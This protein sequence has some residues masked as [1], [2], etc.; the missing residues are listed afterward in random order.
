MR[1]AGSAAGDAVSGAWPLGRGFGLLS[2][3]TLATTYALVVL[4]GVVR[5]TAS[6]DACPDWPRCHGQLIPPFETAVLIEFSHRLLASVVGFLVLAVAIVVWRH[7]KDRPLIAWAGLTA[8]AM[9]IGQIILGGLT[10][11]N[12]LSA[13][14]VMAHL[15]MASVLLA[16]LIVIT[17][18]AVVPPLQSTDEGGV[19]SYAFRNQLIV[20]AIAIFALML[21]GSYVSGSGAALAY[22]DWPL[23]DGALLP[24]GG[25]L[26][27]IH[28][29]HRFSVLFVG[30][31]VAYVAA[32][33]WRSHAND[34]PVLL[35][36]LFALTLYLAQAMVGAANI[37]TLLQAWAS[38]MHLA[39]AALLWA[40]LVTMALFAHRSAQAGTA[41]AR[42]GEAPRPQMRD[43]TSSAAV[44]AVEST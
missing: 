41:A 6:G 30:L 23:F 17:F 35:G 42:D 3:V 18:S 14:L 38:A 20:V 39:L 7:R 44:P 34:R 43:E 37:W 9:V 25:R 12:D 19:R 28:A 33:A 5:A 2:I 13:N 24:D 8:V 22:R 29:T 21:T 4:G 32:K 27:V 40:T 15:A 36:A 10:V 11:L 1:E 16:V 26:A 31:L